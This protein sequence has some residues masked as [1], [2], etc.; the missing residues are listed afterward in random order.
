MS[1]PAA[2][3]LR[4]ARRLGTAL[5]VTVKTTCLAAHA[6]PAEF[7]GRADAYETVCA[8][9]GM[10]GNYHEYAYGLVR[11]ADGA[12]FGTLNLAHAIDARSRV[13]ST[14]R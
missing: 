10:S 5:P 13:G 1:R 2:R 14:P 8:A 3:M 9:W 11:G 7:D 4:T 12:F 6:L